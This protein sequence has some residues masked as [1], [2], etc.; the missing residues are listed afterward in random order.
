MAITPTTG[1]PPLGST[2]AIMGRLSSVDS[3]L[4]SNA[5]TCSAVAAPTRSGYV[6]HNRTCDKMRSRARSP[7]SLCSGRGRAAAQTLTEL[8]LQQ[9]D[10]AQ[11]EWRLQ[12]LA[13]LANIPPL[14][15]DL[16]IR[17]ASGRKLSIRVEPELGAQILTPPPMWRGNDRVRRCPST[18]RR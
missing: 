8:R 2:A 16:D 9:H 1:W 5:A 15:T 18:R 7:A 12:I 11:A 3:V 4:L 14:E 6:A 10:T 17:F 13:N